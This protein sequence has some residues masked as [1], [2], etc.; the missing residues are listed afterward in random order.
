M[1]DSTGLESF[2]SGEWDAEKHGPKT[3][4]S[5]RKLHLAV[6]AGAGEIVALTLTEGHADDVSQL[7]ALLGQV[8]GALAFVTADGADVG[9]TTY[10]V[11][12]ARQHLPM[13]DV[14]VPPRASAVPS[15]DG[16]D[17]HT[18]LDFGLF[19]LGSMRLR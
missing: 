7:P 10:A 2:G 11:A 17:S 19:R 5:W 8:E 9:E 16:S 15:S 3:R 13:P 6:D 4:R 1:L 12:A 14:L 18:Q